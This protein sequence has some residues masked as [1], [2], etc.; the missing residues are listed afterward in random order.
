MGAGQFKGAAFPKH[1][2][3]EIINFF[4]RGV[5]ERP[6]FVFKNEELNCLKKILCDELRNF[7]AASLNYLRTESSVGI[8]EGI[9][10]LGMTQPE[11]M[12]FDS[13]TDA[14]R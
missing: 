9:T 14:E 4:D 10:Y 8:A 7:V 12:G 11:E 3:D 2:I 5:C 6:G 1:R 13:Y